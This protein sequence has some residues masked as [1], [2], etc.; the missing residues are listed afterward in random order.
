MSLEQTYDSINQAIHA[1]DQKNLVQLVNQALEENADPKA[2]IEEVMTPAMTE[3]GNR[4]QRDEIFLPE[5]MLAAE[6][7]KAAIAV[8]DPVLA[9]SKSEMKVKGKVLASTVKGDL[10][11]IGKNL[12]VTMFQ[13]T[14]FEVRDLGVN[15]DSERVV[16][17]AESFGADII[18]LSALLTTTMSAQQEV[19]DVLKRERLR[20]KYKV[21]IGGAPVNQEWANTIGADGYADT[22]PEGC[23]IASQMLEAEA[24]N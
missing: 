7:F 21:I 23:T 18:A 5:L 14:G 11:D 10:H 15:V 12:L 9:K 16:E 6:A 13:T 17:E 2:L 4:F 19:I 8:L 24:Q 3:V 1:F 22:A 20:E